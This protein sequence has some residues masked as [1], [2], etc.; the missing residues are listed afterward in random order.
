MMTTKNVLGKYATEGDELDKMM[1]MGEMAV[2]EP[3]KEI[4][5]EMD[6]EPEVTK[7]ANPEPV[8]QTHDE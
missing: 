7:P 1:G 4:D 3:Q 8:V 5:R 2:F 6:Q